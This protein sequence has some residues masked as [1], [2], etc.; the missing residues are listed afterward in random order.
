MS[1]MLHLW[2]YCNRCDAE[3]EGPAYRPGSPPSLPDAQAVAQ[4]AGWVVWEFSDVECSDCRHTADNEEEGSDGDA[5]GDEPDTS[6]D[7]PAEDV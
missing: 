2:L 6:T 3:L 1:A 5:D 7:N 4:E